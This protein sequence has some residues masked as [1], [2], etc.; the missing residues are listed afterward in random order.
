MEIIDLGGHSGCK[1]LL[2]ETDD[3]KRFVRKISSSV[4]YNK[5]LETQARKQ[6]EFK[7]E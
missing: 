5:R 2:C 3:N 6:K 1:I 4:S 7:S